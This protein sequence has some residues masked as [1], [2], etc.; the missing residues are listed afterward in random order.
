MS[1]PMT[2]FCNMPHNLYDFGD[3]S[4]SEKGK[5]LFES[6]I[7]K[8]LP[9]WVHWCGDELIAELEEIDDTPHLSWRERYAIVGATDEEIEAFNIEK[10]VA[11]ASEEMTEIC[12]P[13]YWVEA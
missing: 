6:L 11:A 3:S 1:N 12:D 2:H 8:R 7:A 4:L 13:E 10:I 5:E 9:S